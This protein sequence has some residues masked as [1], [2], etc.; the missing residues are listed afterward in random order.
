[1]EAESTGVQ[2][3]QLSRYRESEYHLVKLG[4]AL[5][6][7]DR[8]QAVAYAEAHVGAGFGFLVMVS[9][10]VWLGTGFRLR[11]ARADHQI[12]S[13]L[14]AHALQEAGQLLDLDATFALPADVAK[15]LDVRP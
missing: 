8:N 12:C 3:N 10:V 14:V 6:D 9:L 7:T 1:V 11:L 13:G 2:R 4:P 15:A 5:S